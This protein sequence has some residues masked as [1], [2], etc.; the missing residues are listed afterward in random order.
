MGKCLFMRKGEV[1]TAPVGGTP[2]A[3]VAVGSTLKLLENG[4]LV[5]YLVVHSG[6]PSTLYDSSCDGVWLLRKELYDE[7]NW[8][9]GGVND[10][11]N[12]SIHVFLNGGFLALFDKSVQNAIKQVKIPYWKGTGSSG[13]MMTGANGLT[14]KAFLLSDDEIG[15]YYYDIDPNIGSKLDYF[16]WSNADRSGFASKCI[17][18]LNGAA[19]WWHTRSPQTGGDGAEYNMY[20]LSVANSGGQGAMYARDVGE[21]ATGTRPCIILPSTALITEAG[22]IIV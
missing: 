15:M 12:S 14:A 11:E 9:T 1:H 17:A 3:D 16:V 19:A 13:S 10:Y 18:Y 5:D 8:D 7:P 20:V 22:T 6:R 21:G 2:I 4:S